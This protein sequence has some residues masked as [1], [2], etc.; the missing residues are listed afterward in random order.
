MQTFHALAEVNLD[1]ASV[2]TVGTFDGVHLGHQRLLRSVVDDAHTRGLPAAVIT[3]HPHPRIV[4]GRAPALYLTLPGEKAEQ[5]ELLGVDV[6]VV[7]TFDRQ[8]ML[9][10]AAEFV[11]MMAEHLHLV[12]LWIGPDFAL[13]NRR[14]GDAAYLTEQGARYGFSVNVIAPVSAGTEEVS[15]TRVR[16]ALAR[17]DVREAAL[18]LGR[19]F[20]VTGALGPPTGVRVPEQHVVPATGAYRALVCGAPERVTVSDNPEP[21]LICLEGPARCEGSPGQTVEIDFLDTADGG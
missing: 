3:F 11:R 15:S 21:G 5:M 6:L 12:S 9:T 14:Q 4:L 18:C 17:G 8:T 19:P 13:G 20:R 10:T 1:T 2:C 7:M 16:A